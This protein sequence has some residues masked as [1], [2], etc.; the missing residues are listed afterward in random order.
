MSYASGADDARPQLLHAKEMSLLPLVTLHQAA[1]VPKP[2]V[3]SLHDKPGVPQTA[4]MRRAA[5]G[6]PRPD[7]PGQYQRDR[8]GETMAPA[9]R[10]PLMQPSTI[11]SIHNSSGIA[12][13]SRWLAGPTVTTNGMP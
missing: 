9:R 8:P 4:A 1:E 13:S 10:R 3:R 12:V 11:H 2:T 7:A 6:D 5:H